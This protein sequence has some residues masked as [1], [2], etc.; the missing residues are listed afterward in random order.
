MNANTELELRQKLEAEVD[1]V[2]WSALIRHFAF[3][4]VY[5]VRAPWKL[6]DAAIAMH[7]DAKDQVQDALRQK[8][9]EQ[10]ADAEAQDWLERDASFDVLVISPFV[11]IQAKSE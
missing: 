9:L 6:I 1:S 10:P 5:V 7:Q 11:L 8:H 3:G 4:R 2:P